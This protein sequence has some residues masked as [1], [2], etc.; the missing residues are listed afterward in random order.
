[1]LAA[2][3][4]A[5]VRQQRAAPALWQAARCYATGEQW[6]D[7]PAVHHRRCL[8]RD[9]HGTAAW[10]GLL[11]C[12]MLGERPPGRAIVTCRP[13]LLPPPAAAT[14]APSLQAPLPCLCR[15]VQG[16]GAAVG[17]RVPTGWQ[18]RKSRVTCGGRWPPL[19]CACCDWAEG[20]RAH[21]RCAA[22]AP[23]PC[24]GPERP[25]RQQGCGRHRLHCQ[26]VRPLQNDW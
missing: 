18:L 11:G 8:L 13:C 14:S 17:C 23:A 24:L 15:R 19:G 20:C 10:S 21:A 1:M 2:A 22:P 7:R 4:R 16:G 25:D 6:V 12:A 9:R 26:V 5:L 3:S